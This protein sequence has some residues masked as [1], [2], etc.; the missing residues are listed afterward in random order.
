MAAFVC[1][2]QGYNC[3]VILV[4]IKHLNILNDSAQMKKEWAIF[5]TNWQVI[6]QY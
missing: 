1:H 6:S 2:I 5:W 3:E 4:K